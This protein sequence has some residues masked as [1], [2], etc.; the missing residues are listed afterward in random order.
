[1]S[2]ILCY[3][4]THPTSQVTPVIR[5]PTALPTHEREPK[6]SLTQACSLA[7]TARRKLSQEAARGDL[8]L[9]LLVSHAKLLDGFTLALAN[10]ERKQDRYSN[11]MVKGAAKAAKEPKSVQW[12]D[13]ITIA[14]KAVHKVHDEDFENDP[15]LARTPSHN[16]PELIRKDVNSES[17]DLPIPTST[18]HTGIPPNPFSEMKKHTLASMSFYHSMFHSPDEAF[19]I[20]GGSQEL[21]IATC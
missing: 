20:D 16:P 1:M 14:E 9:R 5:R 3:S 15:S 11:Q 6:L 12:A 19:V 13:Q 17:E 4:S 18:P 2:S 7:C 10:N 8:D 21:A